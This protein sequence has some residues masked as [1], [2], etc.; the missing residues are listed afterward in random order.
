MTDARLD[1]SPLL[2]RTVEVRAGERTYRVSTDLPPM[3]L[4]RVRRWFSA[5]ERAAADE[6]VQVDA[7]ELWAV[8]AE[9]LG[10]PVE[11]AQQLGFAAACQLLAFLL[12]MQARPPTATTKRTR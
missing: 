5:Y 3:L 4:V 2:P 1:L 11:E 8:V 6:S 7:A 12:S 10:V 9:V